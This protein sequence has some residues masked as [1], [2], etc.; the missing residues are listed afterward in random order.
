MR[1]GETEWSA[2]GRHTGRIDIPLSAEGRARA[3]ALASR[4]A[5]V[6]SAL[7]LRSPLA[8]AGQTAAL[9]GYADRAQICDDLAEWDY[10]AYEG[11]TTTE[12]RADRPDWSLWRDGAPGGESPDEIE[13][14]ADRVIERL[15]AAP[16]DVVV[17]AHGHLLRV[18]AARWLGLPAVA[19]RLFALSAGSLSVLG[20]ERETPV[21]R[22]W[23]DVAHN[24]A[25][26]VL[27]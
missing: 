23:N 10:G 18:L 12:I 24:C 2:V 20:W 19:G 17:F 4:L 15:R 11:L 6:Q 3:T 8:R 16:G 7:V 25:A 14:R 26:P 21:L 22:L 9:A 1:H 5:D 13:R 27:R